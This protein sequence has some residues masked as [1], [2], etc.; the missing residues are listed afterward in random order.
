M[1]T[2]IIKEN[3]NV[4]FCGIN[5]GLKSA[6]DGHHFSGRSNRFW[7]V[8]HQAGFTPYQIEAINDFTILDFQFGLTTA[9]ARATSRADQLSKKEF[10]DAIDIFK[11]KIEQFKP[12]YIAF[13]GKAAYKAFSGK[14]QITWGLQSEDFCG[15]KVWILPNPSGLNRGFSLGDLVTSYSELRKAII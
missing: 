14:K 7:K 6:S 4:L 11:S 1:L 3:L 8:L 12:K 9:V 5:P 2:D 10:D 15:A 13:L